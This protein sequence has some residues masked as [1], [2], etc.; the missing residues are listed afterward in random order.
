[1]VEAQNRQAVERDLVDEGEKTFDQAIHSLIEIHMLAVDVG[2]HGDGG[3]KEQ[4]RAIA[5][6]GLSHQ[7]FP[8]SQLG[9][10]SQRSYSS[11]DHHGGIHP[12]GAQNG[13]DHRR[14]GGLAVAFGPRQCRQSERGVSSQAWLNC[15]HEALG[16][17]EY[18]LFR[19]RLTAHASRL[20]INAKH[21]STIFFA[22]SVFPSFR[23]AS[24]MVSSR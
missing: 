20:S 11:P 8:L 16:N 4:K 6:I 12:G 7:N 19:S 23:A 2:D 9:V 13:S 14:R 10:A 1:M 5:L 17:S 22:A 18:F 21:S 24:P 3:R 15:R